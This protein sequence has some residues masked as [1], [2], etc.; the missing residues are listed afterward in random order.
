MNTLSD[1]PFGPRPNTAANRR[2]FL[3]I[4][5][6]TV[7]VAGGALTVWPL[8]DNMNPSANVRA[9]ATIEFDLQP[10]EV[11]QRVTVKW[12]GSPL[13]IVRRSPDQIAAAKTD[14]NNIDLIDPATDASR[15][16]REEWLIVIGVCTHLGCIPQGQK[17]GDLR[18][19]WGGWF[20][21]CHGSV[22]DI[23]GRVRRGPAPEN[24][25]LPPYEFNEIGG[26]VIG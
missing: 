13:F 6:A 22:Y 18:G 7:A 4:A 1:K 25:W 21:A 8:I 10:I 26:V 2:D 20:C 16:K 3:F 24:L 17:D 19:D 14:D 12:R 23:A 15:V 5:T 11:G 9:L